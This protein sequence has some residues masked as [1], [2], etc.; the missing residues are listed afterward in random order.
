M[1]GITVDPVGTPDK[2]VIIVGSCIYGFTALMIA[3]AW[4]NIKYR[5]IRAKNMTWTTLIHIA[6]ILWF[7]GDLPTNG[8]VELKGVWIICKLWI[9]W[10]RI[11][12]CYIFALL[13]MVRFFALDRVFN[14]NKPFRGMT[15][16]Y[17]LLVVLLFCVIFAIISQFLP[18]TMTVSTTVD[19]EL[20]NVVMHYRIAAVVV[21]WVLWAGVAVL[22]FRLRN[23]QSSFNEFHESLAIF[24]VAICILLESSVTL[25]GFEYYPLIMKHRLEKTLMDCLGSNIMVWLII[26]QPVYMCIFN[27]RGFEA[28]WLEKL[29]RDGRKAAYEVSS[30]QGG[31]TAYYKM[32]ERD[33]SMMQSSHINFGSSE[34]I[35]TLSAAVNGHQNYYDINALSPEG[36]TLTSPEAVAFTNNDGIPLALRNN[37]QIRRPVLNTPTM[38][39]V[40]FADPHHDDRRIL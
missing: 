34:A 32:G 22:I 7:V 17:A 24:L 40:G 39:N 11:M 8:L 10:F 15:N 16:V 14:Q 26:G 20:C 29:T 6:G 3:F 18:S 23:I 33:T 12:C 38:F 36:N 28:Q 13:H 21:Q 4:L 25:L 2:I 1:L 35:H 27:R 37:L 31:T 9:I 19:I 5:P 30:G